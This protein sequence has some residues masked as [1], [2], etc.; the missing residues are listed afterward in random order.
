MLNK[1]LIFLARELGYE[2]LIAEVRKENRIGLKFYKYC[3]FSKVATLKNQVKLG[4]RYDD[5]VLME[6]FI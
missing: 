6:K 3:G 5:V 2:K 1:T 4:N